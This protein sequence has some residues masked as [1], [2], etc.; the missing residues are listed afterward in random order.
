[1]YFETKGTINEIYIKTFRQYFQRNNR[2]VDEY[3]TQYKT[4]ANNVGVY[5]IQELIKRINDNKTFDP[6]A[7]EYD[8]RVEHYKLLHERGF[9]DDN[10]DVHTALQGT[11]YH[12]ENEKDKQQ[13]ANNG[14]KKNKSTNPPK[15]AEAKNNTQHYI[16]KKPSIKS[17]QKPPVLN[18]NIH[19][20]GAQPKTGQK[21]QLIGYKS[22]G[23]S[24]PDEMKPQT[25]NN[26]SEQKNEKP[27]TQNNQG[28]KIKE[29]VEKHHKNN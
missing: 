26:Q 18:D 24:V 29:K 23:K 10:F 4:T 19:N 6:N 28:K 25:K 27:K 14:E 15:I 5:A 2:E 13:S 8:T 16:T 3:N 22:Q 11:I 21:Q 12:N 9:Y 17:Q 20:D 1:M 7:T